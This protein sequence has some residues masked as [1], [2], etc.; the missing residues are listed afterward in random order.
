MYLLIKFPI[1]NPFPIPELL[2]DLLTVAEDRQNSGSYLISSQ[3]ILI[4]HNQALIIYY[5]II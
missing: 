5:S 2:T 1:T 3:L 4:S